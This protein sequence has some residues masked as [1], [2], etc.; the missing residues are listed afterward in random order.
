MRIY[1]SDV[2]GPKTVGIPIPQAIVEQQLVRVRYGAYVPSSSIPIGAT[3]REMRQLI[4]SAR[5]LSVD[6]AMQT[7]SRP[8]FTLEAALMIQGMEVWSTYPEVVYRRR[9]S[10]VRRNFRHLPPMVIRGVL[11]PEVAERQIVSPVVYEEPCRIG[12]VLTAPL[13][14]VA[15]DCARYLHPMPAVVAVSAVLRRLS[16]FNDRN[17]EA[18]RLWE[19]ECRAEMLEIAYE[20]ENRGSRQAQAVIRVADAGIKTADEGY[21]LWALTCILPGSDRVRF[22]LGDG[23]LAEAAGVLA[24]GID[25]VTRHEIRTSG[26]R[27]FAQF[28]IPSCEVV[29]EFASESGGSNESSSSKREK[30]SGRRHRDM[31]NA[32][33]RVICVDRAHLRL[34]ETFIRHLVSELRRCGVRTRQPFGGLWRPVTE[35]ILGQMQ[36]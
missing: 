31:M 34:P 24:D 14:Q 5:M 2:I 20:L 7:S 27:Y 35:D 17:M 1:K 9:G 6:L 22:D 28:A 11:I 23:R 26:G 30:D 10:E 13:I 18:G 12:D 15:V 29:I 3:E 25:L 33:W 19:N 4:T 21:L 36:P 16:F 8:E 32:G